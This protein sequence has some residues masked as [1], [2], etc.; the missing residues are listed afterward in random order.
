MY[1]SGFSPPDLL[2]ETPDGF[3]TTEAA[4]VL[5]VTVEL[6]SHHARKESIR[7]A[8]GYLRPSEQR[9]IYT[10][11]D[12]VCRRGQPGLGSDAPAERRYIPVLVALL[13]LARVLPVHFD[14]A[15]ATRGM[16]DDIQLGDYTDP[17]KVATALRDAVS[18]L[19]DVS[20]RIDDFVDWLLCRL[21][22]SWGISNRAIR[23]DF[24]PLL[25]LGQSPQGSDWLGELVR[26][27]VEP[28]LRAAREALALFGRVPWDGLE[29]VY[30][31]ELVE[32][33]D[34]VLLRVVATVYPYRVALLSSGDIPLLLGELMRLTRQ[35]PSQ[36]TA[37]QIMRE[38]VDRLVETQP[39]LA[40]LRNLRAISHGVPDDGVC[41][42]LEQFQQE[43]D[44]QLAAIRENCPGPLNDCG[45]GVILQFGASRPVGEVLAGCADPCGSKRT[46]V[47]TCLRPT[48]ERNHLRALE[49][50]KEC[51][52][53]ARLVSI[54]QLPELF[55]AR[56][57][58]CLLLGAEAMYR[59]KLGK[60]MFLNSYGSRLFVELAIH[61]RVPIYVVLE[62]YKVIQ[63]NSVPPLPKREVELVRGPLGLD[64]Q[65]WDLAVGH[66]NIPLSE[67]LPA[68]RVDG[69]LTPD[70]FVKSPEEVLEKAERWRQRMPI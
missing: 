7:K 44:L 31:N 34:E 43:R 25:K 63:W 47:S 6:L 41:A 45:E 3:F 62:W 37:G 64:R 70:G 28:E 38:T 51:G 48:G 15:A 20:E 30:S 50:A 42:R 2:A 56:E 13:R 46:V 60:I 49:V 21:H 55:D 10:V 18:A 29:I 32:T 54:C 53:D 9:A 59:D 26:E 33:V 66:E 4:M 39:N 35:L 68:S 61:W 36:A 17:V 16:E 12:G 67:V 40:A 58:A 24:N 23:L 22:Q 27:R 19:G 11:M 14:W 69:F 52:H 57:I 8:S 65:G 5:A 1:Y